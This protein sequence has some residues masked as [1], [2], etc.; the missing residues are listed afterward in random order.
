MREGVCAVWAGHLDK[1]DAAAA[2]EIGG[3]ARLRKVRDAPSALE[4]GALM[5]EYCNSHGRGALVSM[6]QEI[7]LW[8]E[9]EVVEPLR[10]AGVDAVVQRRR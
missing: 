4:V 3:R 5:I 8:C 9:W 2:E 7:G 1:S 6:A 10:R